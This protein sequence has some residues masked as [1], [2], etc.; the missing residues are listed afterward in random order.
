MYSL[1][2]S[3][4]QSIRCPPHL[5]LHLINVPPTLFLSANDVPV[6]RDRD[7]VPRP[8][9]WACIPLHWPETDRQGQGLV[10]RL[11][12]HLLP[13]HHYSSHA[14]LL[15]PLLL[16]LLPRHHYSSHAP[17]LWSRPFCY[18]KCLYGTCSNYPLNFFSFGLYYFALSYIRSYYQSEQLVKISSP[19]AMYPDGVVRW[20][21]QVYLS[22][23]SLINH[24]AFVV[25][26]S[27]IFPSGGM[28]SYYQGPYLIQ[29]S[30]SYLCL[31]MGLSGVPTWSI[32]RVPLK[33]YL[34]P[35]GLIN[36]PIFFQYEF[37]KSQGRGPH[38]GIIFA[39]P[40]L[41]PP[42]KVRKSLS[43]L[44]LVFGVLTAVLVIPIRTRYKNDPT[45]TAHTFAKF[46]D[47]AS[48]SCKRQEKRPLTIYIV[49]IVN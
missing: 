6:P 34:Y 18:P 28:I 21:Y 37:L 40:T 41:S 16:H 7:V 15:W 32:Y 22:Y 33:S 39:S 31:L 13:R 26:V 12:M 47:C 3:P 19:L 35:T 24:V 27:P 46:C 44:I 17:L 2:S 49:P 5:P 4:P 43:R 38:V 29:I 8:E 36:R 42:P 45:R 1:L 20:P 23:V 9:L 14:P 10:I 48:I 11:L 30:C 25:L